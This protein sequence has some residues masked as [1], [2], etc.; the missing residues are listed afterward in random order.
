MQSTVSF[1]VATTVDLHH[2][3]FLRRHSGARHSGRGRL[4]Y[5]WPM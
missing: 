3:R 4:R 5:S 1:C 2:N